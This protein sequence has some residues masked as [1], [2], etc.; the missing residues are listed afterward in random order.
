[1]VL[2]QYQS[3]QLFIEELLIVQFGIQSKIVKLI[4]SYCKKLRSM[5]LMRYPIVPIEMADGPEDEE[6]WTPWK[7]VDSKVTIEDI[8]KLESDIGY[9]LPK[10]FEELLCYKHY[11]ELDFQLVTFFP[12]PSDQGIST[13][14]SWLIQK[15]EQYGLLKKGYS[16]FGSSSDDESY[17]CFS[18]YESVFNK[19]IDGLD[20]PIVVI[21]PSNDIEN[22]VIKA[23][24]SFSS[25]VDSLLNELLVI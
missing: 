17:Y 21:D 19:D 6:G 14:R 4:D 11:L 8:Q 15:S 20:C 25:M 13:I 22:N 3:R 5:D 18:L 7:L 2:K 16:I 10:L 1:M 12:F 24:P 9:K 23:F